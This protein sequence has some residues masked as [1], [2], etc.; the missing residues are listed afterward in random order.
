MGK[1]LGLRVWSNTN[2]RIAVIAVAAMAAAAHAIEAA[3]ETNIAA[4]QRQS[5]AATKAHEHLPPRLYKNY[6][7]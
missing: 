3:T 6:T 2:T 7:G 4:C 1:H 5:A